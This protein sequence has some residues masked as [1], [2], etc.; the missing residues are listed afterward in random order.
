V[1]EADVAPGLAA[2]ANLSTRLYVVAALA[3]AARL[4]GTD[5]GLYGSPATWADVLR[6][7]PESQQAASPSAAMFAL[8]LMFPCYFV[9]AGTLAQ[10]R[11]YTLAEKLTRSA[12]VTALVFV[13]IPWAIAIFH[14]VRAETGLALRMPRP[15]VLPAALLLGLSLWPYAH[16]IF[17]LNQWLGIS[18]LSAG[19]FA[20]ARLFAD[21][22]RDLP[23]AL[24]LITLAVAPGVCEEFFFRGLLFGA[25]SRTLSAWGTIAAAAVLFGLFHVVVGNVFLPERFLPS[26]FLGLA[27]GWVRWRT[28]SVVPTMIIHTTHNA[29]LLSVT[30]WQERLLTSGIAVDE[31]SHLPFSWLAAAA[32]ASAAAAA[33]IHA[34]GSLRPGRTALP[35]K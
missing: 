24:V 16:E 12:L 19:Q 8:A 11:D 21:Q 18:D 22:L 13:T 32:L 1:L 6:R 9:A 7:P 14:R 29:V 17:L 4:F 20:T 23:F 35:K 28:A 27:L 34:K 15:V 26:A 5:G 31:Q 10:M 25:L 30:Y 3:Q 33:L 2:A